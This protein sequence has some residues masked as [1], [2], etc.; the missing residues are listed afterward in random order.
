MRKYVSPFFNIMHEKLRTVPVLSL[1]N[2]VLQAHY[3]S[4]SFPNS[5]VII[6]G[7]IS[8]IN[9]L[10]HTYSQTTSEFIEFKQRK[11][12]DTELIKSF[13]VAILCVLRHLNFRFLIFFSRKIFNSNKRI[14]LDA[15]RFLL[16]YSFSWRLTLI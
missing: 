5:S 3:A 10:F 16:R 1:F 4:R 15:D 14:M 2:F 7:L 13:L 8:W 12:E 11:Y 9:F 6:G